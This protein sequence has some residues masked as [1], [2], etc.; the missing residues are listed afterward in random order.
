MP[1]RA[2]RAASPSLPPRST[3]PL[4]RRR[5]SSTST[6]RSRSA[7][8]TSISRRRG[9]S[10]RRPPAMRTGLPAWKTVCA[11]TCKP[12]S[13]LPIAIADAGDSLSRLRSDRGLLRALRHPLVRARLYRRA[14]PRLALLPL[15]RKAPARRRLASGDRRFPRLGD[16]RRRA[17]RPRRLCPLLQARLLFSE[18]ERDSEAVAW[19]HVVP[20]RRARR[21]RGAVPVLPPARPV[22]PRLLRHHHQ[23]RADRVVLRPRRQFHQWRA[24]GPAERC[25]LGDGLSEWRARAAPSEPAL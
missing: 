22:A 15:G 5:S 20:W 10:G 17:R 8:N 18:P 9:W 6:P 24:V 23:R 3:A 19:R 11:I 16:A 4:A 1:A 13:P 7:T 2:R 14:D 21:A 25:A 12:T